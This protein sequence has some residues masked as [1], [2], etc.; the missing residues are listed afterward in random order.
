M[1]NNKRLPSGKETW[2]VLGISALFLLLTGIFVG[3]RPEHLLII[4]LFLFLFFIGTE[5][6]KLAV[7]LLP[8]IIFGVSYDWMRVYP[9]YMVNPIDVQGLYEAEKAL[10][11][12]NIEGTRLIPC[13]Y[14]AM[15]HNSVADFFAG[16][17]YLTWVPVPIAFGLWLYFIKDRK[18]YL[19]FSIVFL[20]VNLLGF[21][22]YYIHPAAPPWY[23]INYGF[24]PI[25]NTPG[26]AAGLARFDEL[27][28]ISVFDSIYGRN[29]NV[30]AAVPS[31]HAAYMLIAVVYAFIKKVNWIL[32][33]ILSVLCV[34]IWA[35]AVY[36]CHHYIIDVLL[37]VGCALAGILLFEKGLMKLH[38]F[39]RFI[40]RYTIYIGGSEK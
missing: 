31:L 39:Q 8:F 14:F 17:F 34:G 13:E 36:S 24:E 37:G 25:L 29:A 3:L 11:G 15:H 23:A 32:I 18:L 6:R 22:G 16:I 7:A 28:G 9:N 33:T 26:N 27:L 35:T 19:R 21:A 38:F 5:T 1:I 30:F 4:A 12:I 20:F 2:I 40:D 10:F